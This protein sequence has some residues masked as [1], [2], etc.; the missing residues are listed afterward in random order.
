MTLLPYLVAGWVF[1]VGLYGI[2]TSR[3]LVHTIVCLSVTE[4]GTFLFL[5]A[6]AH[7]AG[8]G[9]PVFTATGNAP[10]AADPVLHAL[11][12]VDVVVGAAITAL[13]LAVAV[14]VHKRTGT[15]DPDRLH[16][17]EDE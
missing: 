15:L 2:V 9:A 3:N 11:A 8:R 7:R 14:E 6:L 10:P 1:L 16:S 4:S 12:L 13:L 17:T 5:V